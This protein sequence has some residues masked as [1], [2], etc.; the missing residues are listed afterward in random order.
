[1]IEKSIRDLTQLD[2][3]KRL[4]QPAVCCCWTTGGGCHFFYLAVVWRFVPAV[5]CMRHFYSKPPAYPECVAK[6]FFF[7]NG[8][9]KREYN[10]S[11]DIYHQDEGL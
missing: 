10:I 4:L 2:T 6:V 1:M 9:K 5:T 7:Y 8:Q 3:Q 11:K